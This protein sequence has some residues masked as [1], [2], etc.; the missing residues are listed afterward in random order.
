MGQARKGSSGNRKLR[1]PPGGIRV[2][3]RR[4]GSRLPR[5]LL[6]LGALGGAAA[7]GLLGARGVNALRQSMLTENPRFTL[8]EIVVDGAAGLPVDDVIRRSG[9][10]TGLYL[11]GVD[12]GIV[13]RRLEA[14]PNILHAEVLRE[15]PG[16]LRIRIRERWP[17][18]RLDS[19]E[20]VAEDGTI[21]DASPLLRT[22][23]GRRAAEALPIVTGVPG[24]PF[25]PGERLGAEWFGPAAQLLAYARESRLADRVRV[26]CIDVAA[27]NG[28]TLYLDGG[29]T[30]PMAGDDIEQQLRR[31]EVILDE[32]KRDGR[33]PATVDLTAG[34]N[35]PVTFRN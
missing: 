3:S 35:V 17:I 30:V 4:G 34:R 20:L 10:E 19:G 2:R 27:R 18:A 12:L 7:I 21:L 31:L 5:L 9:L 32:T 22:S 24:R 8:A 28:L 25:R 14:V 15:M 33:T 16:T 29:Q 1:R 6:G 26:E 13:R 23:E 11:P